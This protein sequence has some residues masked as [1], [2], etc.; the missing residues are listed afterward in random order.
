MA[1]ANEQIGVATAAFYPT[2][3]LS[4]SAGLESQTIADWF[5]WPSRFWSVGPV[6]TQTL[7]DAGKRRA[8]V[9][10]AKDNYDAMV[11]SYR[12]TVLTAFQ[13][14]EDEL[15]ALRILEDEARAEALAVKAAQ[16]SL[17]ITTYQYKAGIAAYLQVIIAQTA[18]LQSERTAI[19]ILTRRLAASVLLIQAVGG[20]WDSSRLPT[21]K[22]VRTQRR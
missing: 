8:Q 4:A 15:A 12:Q 5:S 18:A 7:F 10:L 22:D 17:D 6:L 16:Q 21:E 14:V 9:N 19:D 3:T 13:Q 20:G 11:A 2:L 1:S